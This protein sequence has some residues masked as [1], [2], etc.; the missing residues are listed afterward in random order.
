MRRQTTRGL[1]SWRKQSRRYGRITM[2]IILGRHDDEPPLIAGA[3]AEIKTPH[4]S[5]F[6]SH[7]RVEPATR[8][9][10]H[11]VYRRRWACRRAQARGERHFVVCR[12]RARRF[13]IPLNHMRRGFSSSDGAA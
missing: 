13:E 7:H 11:F 3:R 1:D 9:L 4:S 10:P 2:K 6:I 12:R 5:C 8:L